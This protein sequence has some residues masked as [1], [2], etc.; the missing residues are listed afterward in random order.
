MKLQFIDLIDKEGRAS[1]FSI[2]GNDPKKKG[3][4]FVGGGLSHAS[5]VRPKTKADAQKLI[6][7]LQGLEY[8]E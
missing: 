7:F 5:F 8:Q 3:Y 1:H 4:F 6:D 2:G